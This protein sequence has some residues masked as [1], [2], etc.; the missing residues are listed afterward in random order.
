MS[1]LLDEV[2]ALRKSKAI[3]YE[4]YLKRIGELAKRVEVGGVSE[5]P[6][7][8]N[9]KGKLAI[10]NMLQRILSHSPSDNSSLGNVAES[11]SDYVASVDS[12][13]ELTL[14]I[15]ERVRQVRPHSWKG[16]QA[17]EAI[18]YDAVFQLL[19]NDDKA[20]QIFAVLLAQEEY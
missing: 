12:V 9:S 2:I 18:V 10:Y 17:K 13:I 14:R 11:S 19:G 7:G 3:G 4:E 6:P 15:D 20:E 1:K 8:L 5:A 16:V